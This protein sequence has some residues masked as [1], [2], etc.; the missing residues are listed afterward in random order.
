M[1]LMKFCGISQ[2]IFRI[3]RN[4]VEYLFREMI[5]PKFHEISR[6][7]FNIS[8]NFVVLLVSRKKSREILSNTYFEKWFWQNLSKHFLCFAKFCCVFS[9]VKEIW[10]S[11]VEYL[12]FKK[13][14]SK[15]R[16]IS[17]N[18]FCI[19]RNFVV[20]WVSL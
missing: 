1:I 16:E 14:S 13:L 8:R 5:L 11:F 19:L 12:I 20:L 15:F 18:T 2:T 4:F 6:N 10:Q 7:T 9:F 17:Q 3:S